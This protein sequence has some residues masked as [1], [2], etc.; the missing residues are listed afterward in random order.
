MSVDG[1]LRTTK[2]YVISGVIWFRLD[3]LAQADQN[4]ELAIKQKVTPESAPYHAQAL[5]WKALMAKRLQGDA[6]VEHWLQGL[7]E[8]H[9]YTAETRWVNP[10]GGQP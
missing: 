9:P 8:Q 1:G 2:N 6:Q 10:Q 3:N 5:L 7:L 4:F